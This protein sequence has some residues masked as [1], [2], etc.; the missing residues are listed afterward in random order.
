MC[1]TSFLHV[2]IVFKISFGFDGNSNNIVLASTYFD[3]DGVVVSSS[4]EELSDELSQIY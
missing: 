3:G 2:E 4:D 1:F